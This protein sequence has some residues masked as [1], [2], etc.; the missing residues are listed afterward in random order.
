MR[1]K[2]VLNKV[3]K[4]IR[5]FRLLSGGERV[6]VAVSGGPDSIFLLN[7]LKELQPLFRIELAVAHLNHRLRPEA[8]EEQEFVREVAADLKLDFFTDSV[9]VAAMAKERSIGLEEAARLARY[10][11]L[12]SALAQWGGQLVAL[13][14]TRS[15]LAETIMF[16]LFRGSGI[17]G[18]AGIPPKNDIFIRPIIEIS[19]DEVLSY[20]EARKIRYVLDRS[21]YDTRFT[22]N[23]LRH[24]VIPV[25]K[26]RF[27]A[28][29]EKVAQFGFILR[30]QA[31]YMR[32]MAQKDIRKLRKPAPEGEVILD[33]YKLLVYH[34]AHRFWIYSTLS[35]GFEITYAKYNDMEY[36]LE[37]GGRV[38]LGNG[39]KLESSEG[40]FRFYRNEL[41]LETVSEFGVGATVTLDAPINLELT[42]FEVDNGLGCRNKFTAC[43]P[44]SAVQPPF[45]LRKRASGDKI[46]LKSGW[47]SL[48]KLFIDSKVPRWRREL[49]PVVADQKGILW[50]VG[51]AKS[52]RGN[53]K[54]GS[55]IKMEVKKHHEREF[56]I[57]D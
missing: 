51:I 16:N 56:W 50:I 6:M 13:G 29:E 30:E 2:S 48:K 43:F 24:K 28:F 26:S 21:N 38:F 11:F 39:W 27:P 36:V 35:L 41:Q 20:L 18:V 55:L 12:R 45:I 46:R 17:S 10:S 52:F 54:S 14:H 1:E 49:I 44:K 7:V 5:R 32:E 23:F 31:D 47:K 25:V 4:T 57:Y 53:F 34:R 8:D 22:R 3:I 15:D 37:N 40:D 9:D 33:R 19:R 42:A